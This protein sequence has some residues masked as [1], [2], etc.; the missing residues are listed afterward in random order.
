MQA[1]LVAVGY[2]DTTIGTA[3]AIRRDPWALSILPS[4]PSDGSGWLS[5]GGVVS[6]QL[7]EAERALIAD[8]GYTASAYRVVAVDEADATVLRAALDDVANTEVVVEPNRREVRAAWV[9]IYR[10]IW[11][12]RADHETEGEY[13]STWRS[14]GN[15]PRVDSPPWAVVELFA[16]ELD[17]DAYWLVEGRDV[18]AVCRRTI[19]K[20]VD[21]TSG[22]GWQLVGRTTGATEQD[23]YNDSDEIDWTAGAPIDFA[24][25]FVVRVSGTWG[26]VLGHAETTFDGLDFSSTLAPPHSL[27][28]EWLL[29]LDRSLVGTTGFVLRVNGGPQAI[30]VDVDGRIVTD[31]GNRL[32]A[33]DHHNAP[34]VAEVDIVER[35]GGGI[36]RIDLGGALY[37]TDGAPY[38]GSMGGVTIDLPMAA[39]ASTPSGD[40]YWMVAADGGVFAFGDARFHGSIPGVLPSGVSLASEIV[41][42]E[43]TPSGDGYW[44]LGADGGVF[45]FGDAEYAGSLPAL[46]E[47]MCPHGSDEAAAGILALGNGYLIA[48]RSGVVYGFGA[49]VPGRTVHTY[50]PDDLYGCDIALT[51][52]VWTP[53]DH[54]D[55]G[56][57]TGMVAEA[58]GF[59]IERGTRL[60][61][62]A[63]PEPALGMLR[64]PSGTAP[65]TEALQTS[66][67]QA[68]TPTIVDL[69]SAL[70]SAPELAGGHWLNNGLIATDVVGSRQVLF[71]YDGW[72][73]IA[74]ELTTCEPDQGGG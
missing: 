60:G 71:A 72:G 7:T 23:V 41:D 61:V 73:W 5:W 28:S 26:Q 40:G 37:A 52:P 66:I 64:C 35:P 4:P 21:T 15:L 22:V 10:R 50:R 67:R 11:G 70:R 8:E 42:I 18:S 16:D 24:T 6:G 31:D 43:P 51:G 2:A 1:G 20:A 54:P 63:E 19:D 65:H 48:D 12:F 46:G 13:P 47:T 74:A 38:L 55:F 68:D 57:V 45:T 33:P 58:D 9:Q 59:R 69:A 3:W 32:V 27:A 17:D 30:L 36:W 44:L 25:H 14:R 56:P 39:M 53:P 29:A 62:G 49:D 34:F